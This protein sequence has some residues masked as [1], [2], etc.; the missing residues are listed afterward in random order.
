MAL[1]ESQGI[2]DEAADVIPSDSITFRPSA[3][4]VGST[5]NLHVELA[6]GGEITYVNI[7]AG[8]WLPILVKKVFVADTTASDI[9]RHF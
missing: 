9:V 5:G 2:A 6:K 1:D 8:T 7:V 3:L 4:Y